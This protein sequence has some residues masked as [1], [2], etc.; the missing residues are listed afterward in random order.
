M[1]G[2]ET[3]V[4]ARA[5]EMEAEG[6]QE[7]AEH[8]QRAAWVGWAVVA[9]A[10]AVEGT[11]MEEERAVGELVEVRAAATAVAAMAVMES[12]RSACSRSHPQIHRHHSMRC[13]RTGRSHSKGRG[14]S[15]GKRY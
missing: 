15:L 11:A 10:K 7:G 5:A 8:S 3:A 6:N 12:G 1:A 9:E 14:R 4:V 13:C 2:T